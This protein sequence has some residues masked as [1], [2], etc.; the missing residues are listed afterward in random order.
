LKSI[1]VYDRKKT[2]TNKTRILTYRTKGSKQRTSSVQAASQ[3][4]ESAR[5]NFV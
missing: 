2:A 1:S 3:P 4:D 5:L